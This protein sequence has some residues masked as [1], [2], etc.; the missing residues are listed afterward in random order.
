MIGLLIP[1]LEVNDTHVF[2]PDWT[3]HARLHEVWQLLTNT[4]LAAIGLWLVWFGARIRAASLIGLVI[5][6]A[7]V[8]AYLLRDIYG[9]STT[10][11]DGSVKI[12]FGLN[13]TVIAVYV[14]GAV[15]ALF[16][17]AAFAGS[18]AGNDRSRDA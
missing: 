1:Y 18:L 5:S 9:G 14:M 6:A 16:T 13:A 15:A 11:A 4:T 17:F 8:G 12:I 7:F 10:Y 2:N 3:P